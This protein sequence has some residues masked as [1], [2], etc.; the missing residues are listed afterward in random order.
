MPRVPSD[1]SDEYAELCILTSKQ[2]EMYGQMIR[3][4]ESHR[5]S[6]VK[7][8]SPRVLENSHLT[9]VLQKLQKLDPQRDDG[10]QGA[11]VQKRPQEDRKDKSN[12]EQEEQEEEQEEATRWK[13]E[14]Q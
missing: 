14:V 5:R 12:Q 11:M 3:G 10:V 8:P 2:V 9:W 6:E 4:L 7:C 13:E 1:M